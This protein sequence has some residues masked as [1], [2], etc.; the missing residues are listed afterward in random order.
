MQFEGRTKPCD[1]LY[2]EN[3]DEIERRWRENNGME[4]VG[5]HM[6]SEG[7]LVDWSGIKDLADGAMVQVMVNIHGGMGKRGKKKKQG[8]PWESDGGSGE[9]SSAEEQ[10]EVMDKAAFMEEHRKVMG[11]S[12]VDMWADMEMEEVKAQVEE[13]EEA[14]RGNRGSED[15]GSFELDVDGREEEGGTT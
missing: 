11:N 15:I 6:A 7:R 4:G 14:V 8:N 3:G 9:M 12:Y 1:V 13:F 2:G 5:M 10:F